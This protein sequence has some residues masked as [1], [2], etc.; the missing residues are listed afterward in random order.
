MAVPVTGSFVLSMSMSQFSRL[1][2]MLRRM[3]PL[4]FLCMSGQFLDDMVVSGV[5]ITN[6]LSLTF[7][8]V[9]IDGDEFWHG[10]SLLRMCFSQHGMVMK[11]LM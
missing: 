4:I 6:W 3:V 5:E 2:E 8:S 9:V 1:G 10:T 11:W 7:A